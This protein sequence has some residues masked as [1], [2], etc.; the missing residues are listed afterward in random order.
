M[1]AKANILVVDDEETMRDSCRQALVDEGHRVEV[2]SDGNEGLGLLAQQ[3]FDL[4]I[5]DLKMPGLRGMEVLKRIRQKD[6]EIIVVV[7][8]GYATV[9]SAVEAMKC[10]AYD[11]IPKPFTPESLRVIVTRALERRML[12]LENV[13]LRAELA[14]DRG[15]DVIIGQS[16]SMQKIED[17]IRQVAPT[18]ST[19]LITGETGTGKELVAR[20]IH[21]LS[22]RK[23]KP[24]IVV[25]CGS[26]VESLF[27]SELF[28]HVKGA[29]TGA[30]QTKYGRFEVANGGT[31]FLDEVG[32]IGPS[33]QA[34]LLRVLQEKEITRVGSSQVIG[35]D[36]RIIAASNKDLLTGVED[37]TFRQDLFY[38]L[39]VVPIVLPPLRERKEDIPLLANHFWAKYNKSTSEKVTGISGAAMAVLTEYHW[40]G[41]VRELENVIERTV[42]LTRGGLIKPQDLWRYELSGQTAGQGCGDADRV[43]TLAEVEREHIE[44]TL[45]R[46]D[47][48]IGKAAEALGIDR[49]TLR[50]KL[51]QYE[52]EV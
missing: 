11:Y 51:K 45:H 26:L 2:A 3:A 24:F 34:K 12:S 38:R 20:T 43:R 13:L 8:T 6:H 29:F 25:D 27:E 17:L 28:G 19:V 39:S 42:V 41:N 52:R 10:G 14:Q 48:Q 15:R 35:V 1:R 16:R 22:G 33:I 50:L 31:I 47:G 9:E 5:L 7:I 37:H 18:D 40:P 21:K 44:Q 23:D 30:T 4:V 46:M 32:N 49:K 36:I